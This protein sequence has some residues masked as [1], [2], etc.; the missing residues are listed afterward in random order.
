METCFCHS[1]IPGY[2]EIGGWATQAAKDDAWS[3]Y[4]TA[5]GVLAAQDSTG[6]VVQA[7]GET[8]QGIAQATG[9][10]IVPG[11][12]QDITILLIVAAVAVFA[13]ARRKR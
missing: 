9:N 13:F 8:A 11:T 5:L 4:Q 2:G 1:P 7:L 6:T 10:T 3:K 12:K